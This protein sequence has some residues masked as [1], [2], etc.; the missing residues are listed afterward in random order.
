M[1]LKV[2]IA[3]I[4]SDT[5]LIIDKDDALFFWEDFRMYSIP[6]FGSKKLSDFDYTFG[7]LISFNSVNIGL[8]QIDKKKKRILKNSEYTQIKSKVGLRP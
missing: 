8:G 6:F 2:H 3:C 7:N 4:S 5:E 1:L